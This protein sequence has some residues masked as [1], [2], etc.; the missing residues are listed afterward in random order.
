MEGTILDKKQENNKTQ[1]KEI[2]SDVQSI[3][4]Q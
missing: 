2:G 1:Q 4:E 3:I